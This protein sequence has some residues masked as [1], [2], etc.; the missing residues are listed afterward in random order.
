MIRLDDVFDAAES[1]LDVISE[2][3]MDMAYIV[4]ASVIYFYDRVEQSVDTLSGFADRGHD[5]H[6]YH[7]AQKVVVEF[8]S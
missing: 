7:G 8:C 6:S 2:V 3:Y 5:R 1:G 4:V